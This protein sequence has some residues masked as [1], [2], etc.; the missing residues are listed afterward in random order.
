MVEERARKLVPTIR[1]QE[2]EGQRFN[3]VYEKLEG[4]LGRER[5][6]ELSNDLDTALDGLKGPGDKPK[7]AVQA[8][9]KVPDPRGLIEFL[10]DPENAEEAEAFGRMD[11]FDAGMKAAEIMH[12][13]AAK[14][15]V[16]PERSNAPAP[17]EKVRGGGPKTGAPDFRDTKA[18]IKWRNEQEAK[19][20]D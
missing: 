2:D 12:K 1:K 6:A 9:F 5:F 13:L 4:E 11:G 10:T 8:I 16:H 3:R 17:I 7:A 19:G 14:A 18:W 20:L 15:K